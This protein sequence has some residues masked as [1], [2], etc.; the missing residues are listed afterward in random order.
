MEW[1]I[2]IQEGKIVKSWQFNK[3]DFLINHQIKYTNVAERL[4]LCVDKWKT[5]LLGE[6]KNVNIK[7]SYIRF[8][9]DQQDGSIYTDENGNI[10]NYIKRNSN[11]NQNIST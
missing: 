9:I 8:Y 11:C 1:Y 10:Y 7:K 5:I 2:I 6:M 4:Y 3:M